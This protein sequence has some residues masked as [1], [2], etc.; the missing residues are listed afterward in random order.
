MI[1]LLIAAL[2]F[3]DDRKRALLFS[4]LGGAATAIVAFAAM[5][6]YGIAA[7][8]IRVTLFEIA[9]LGS[10][11]TLTPFDAPA[12]MKTINNIPE[13]L[14]LL[15]DKSAYLYVFWP[16]MM[17]FV[18]AALTSR[19]PVTPRRR[20]HREAFLIIA[21][22]GVIT[23]ISYAERHHLL[24]LFVAAPL[25][26]ITIF[27]LFHSRIPLARAAAPAMVILA[28]MMAQPTAHIAITG[29]L[30]RTHGSMDPD[31]R[32]LALP[33]AQGA[34]SRSSDAA[35][36]DIV[37]RYANSHLKPD[38]TWFDFTN[39]GNLYFL[40]NR[41]CPIRQ[42]EV[43]FYETE[44]RQR[45]VIA[46]I[47]QSPHIRFA[48]MPGDPDTTAV[49]AIANRVRAPLVYAYLLSHFEPDW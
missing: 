4:A 7:D 8:F 42:I 48:L 19:T 14:G 11:Y 20:A 45:E 41:D 40:L 39:R 29:A 30:R 37:N 26:S 24:W 18:V 34:L 38:E 46:R 23:A 3:R 22:F 25:L 15:L 35:I 32:E 1:V 27:R 43:A 21:I 9:T 2:R 12:A 6:I 33:R 36:V 17:L 49:D 31:W 28:L 47:E 44:A 16:L 10:V 13:V 5:A